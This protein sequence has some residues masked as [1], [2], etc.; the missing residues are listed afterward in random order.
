[1]F[2]LIEFL[3]TKTVAVVPKSWY[4][5]GVTYWPNYKSDNRIERAVKNAEEPGSDWEK[6]DVRILKSC[7]QYLEARQLL[8]KSL[9]HN[10]SELQSD[11]EE[12][13]IRGRRKHKPIHFFGDTDND[14]E[15]EVL[16]KKRAKGSQKLQSENNLSPPVIPPPPSS[17]AVPPPPLSPLPMLCTT[18]E[19]PCT[20]VPNR[21]HSAPIPKQPPTASLYRPVWKG[22]RSGTDSIPCSDILSSI[23]RGARHK[24]HNME[25]PFTYFF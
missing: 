10:T 1:M 25:H 18:P 20:W 19:P 5:D 17:S 12:E 24:T 8:R 3:S 21:S 7:N 13:E 9:T 14:S 16:P 6:H 4:A 2:L 23:Y 22:G 15:E 11:E